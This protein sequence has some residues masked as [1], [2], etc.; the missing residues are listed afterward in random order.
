MKITIERLKA[1][2][3]CEAS[4]IRFAELFGAEVEVTEE[5]CVHASR[6]F[7]W[8]WAADILLSEGARALWRGGVSTPRA[9]PC[10]QW[11]A[12]AFA[13]AYNS[14]ENAGAAS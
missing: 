5:V 3:A 4:C 9:G 10:S 13:R 7:D 12:E 6:D 14:P 8:F 11:K 1:C 2:G